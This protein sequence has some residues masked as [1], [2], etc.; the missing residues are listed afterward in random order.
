MGH[1]L[2]WDIDG[3]DLQKTLFASYTPVR[4]PAVK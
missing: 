2:E 3:D 4:R 1:L